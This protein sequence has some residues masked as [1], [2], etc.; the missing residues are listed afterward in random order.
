[1]GRLQTGL[2]FQMI[3]DRISKNELQISLHWTQPKDLCY[4]ASARI[5]ANFPSG[6]LAKLAQLHIV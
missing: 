1:M 5:S 3:G 4:L 6:Y 2:F